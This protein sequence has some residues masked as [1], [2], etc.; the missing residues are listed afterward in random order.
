MMTTH[1]TADNARNIRASPHLAART[2]AVARSPLIADALVYAVAFC[3]ILQA[4][5]QVMSRIS[6]TGDEPWYILQA[7]SLL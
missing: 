4:S 7:L 1:H 2:R 5:L 3:V 6:L